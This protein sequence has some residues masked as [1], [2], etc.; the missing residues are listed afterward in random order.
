MLFILVWECT[1]VHSLQ[2]TMLYVLTKSLKA[3]SFEIQDKHKQTV[4]FFKF[5]KWN[6]CGFSKLTFVGLND[7]G[8]E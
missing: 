3:N 2:I 1:I 8:I 5:R 7:V 6:V 4:F